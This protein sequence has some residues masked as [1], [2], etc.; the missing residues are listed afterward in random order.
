MRLKP[1]QYFGDQLVQRRTDGICLTLCRYRSGQ[2]LPKHAHQNPGFFFLL[3]GDHYETYEGGAWIQPES[4]LLYHGY[5]SPHA[6]DIGPKGMVGL[7]IAFDR[8]WIDDSHLPDVQSKNGWLLEKPIAKEHALRLLAGLSGAGTSDVENSGV[9]LI[10]LIDGCQ[11]SLDRKPPAWLK[12]VREK[13]DAEYKQQLS[14]T[15]CAIEVGVHPVYL[16]RAFR[17]QFGCTFTSYLHQVRMLQVLSLA[18]SGRT[19]GDAAA[20]CGFCDQAY[21]SRVVKAR[22]GLP[23]SALNWFKSSKDTSQVA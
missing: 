4:S 17:K 10:G 5:D 15:K 12:K 16:A 1:G 13:I 7:N 21:L 8:K 3:S 19:F 20:E 9:E 11:G 22:L 2:K 14:L 6:T 23:P 18:A